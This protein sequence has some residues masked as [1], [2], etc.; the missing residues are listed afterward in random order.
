MT[1]FCSLAIM[2]FFSFSEYLFAVFKDV[3]GN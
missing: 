1:V 2:I 3:S